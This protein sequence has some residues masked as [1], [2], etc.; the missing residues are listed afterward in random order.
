MNFFIHLI[1][2]L[3]QSLI[4][5]LY[6]V[7]DDAEVGVIFEVMNDRGKPLSELEKVKNYLIYLTGKISEDPQSLRK[8]VYRY[9]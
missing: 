1:D 6:K 2:K 3:T 8:M 4:F 7:E 5:T 9:K